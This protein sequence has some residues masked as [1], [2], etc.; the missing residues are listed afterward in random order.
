L[1]KYR[2]QEVASNKLEKGALRDSKTGFCSP[3]ALTV[4]GEEDFLIIS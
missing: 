4:P 3:V 2:S 1:K